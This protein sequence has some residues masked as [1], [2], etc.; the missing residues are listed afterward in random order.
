QL[1]LRPTPAKGSVSFSL[2]FLPE[3]FIQLTISDRS[4]RIVK[5][6]NTNNREI[7]W[8]GMDQ[9]GA[10]VPSGVYFASIPGAPSVAFV[11]LR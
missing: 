2:N 6:I 1:S 4:G 3:S 5:T 10:K 11:L 9:Q 7:P 8:D